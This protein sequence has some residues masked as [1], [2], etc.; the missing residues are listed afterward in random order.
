MGNLL[1]QQLGF[2]FLFLLLVVPVAIYL[3]TPK[4]YRPE[5]LT[6]YGL[7]MEKTVHFS[8]G[9]VD[10]IIDIFIEEWAKEF[11]KDIRVIKKILANTDLYWLNEKPK[12]FVAELK[13]PSMLYMWIGPLLKDKTRF[14]G[15]TGLPDQLK[16]IALISKY[17]LLEPE[18]LM[19]I[20]PKIDKVMENVR[21]K[22]IALRHDD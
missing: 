20:Q 15:Y 14:I 6:R 4:R 22:I 8:T 10:L 2:G 13:P 12:D 18:K 21:N 16:N 11:P 9:Q 1:L 5:L 19:S 17:S 7:R 3:S